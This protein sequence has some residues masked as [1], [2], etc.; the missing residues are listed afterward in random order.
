VFLTS[1]L[2]TDITQSDILA[3]GVR[4]FTAAIGDRIVVG[5]PTAS[6]YLFHVLVVAGSVVDLPSWHVHEVDLESNISGQRSDN[7][8]PPIGEEFVVIPFQFVVL[9][10][11]GSVHQRLR[12]TT[13][14]PL[15]GHLMLLDKEREVRG[16]NA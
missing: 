13:S 14:K 4:V 15:F 11:G 7:E 2:A 9:C 5:K 10:P 6:A 3:L 16:F 12:D 1:S 8:L